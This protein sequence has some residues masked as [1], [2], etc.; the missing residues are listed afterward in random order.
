VRRLSVLA[1][2]PDFAR[3]LVRE[4]RV[5]W[6]LEEAG[7]PYEV[8]E[9]REVDQQSPGY[10]ELQPFG[11]VPA[12]EE[13]GLVLFESGAIV[14]HIAER[15]PALLPPSPAGRARALTWMFAA[16]NTVE[17]D[18]SNLATIDHFAS[19]E[20]WAPLRR[21][22]VVDL[23]KD[24]LDIVARR[25]RGRP[26]LEDQFTAADLLMSSVLRILRYTDLVSSVPVLADYCARI[27]ARPAYQRS[28]ADHLAVFARNPPPPGVT[29]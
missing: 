15:S 26:Y 29:A 7:L 21:P 16:L 1:W 25:L 23:V 27:E 10:R 18:I 2:V 6:A 8:R 12:Y 17:P 4:H 5:R 14:H 9:L 3:G 11:Q 20:A 22:A 24:K 28:L 13:D 19:G